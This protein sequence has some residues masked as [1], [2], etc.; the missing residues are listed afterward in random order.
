MQRINELSQG[1]S[2]AANIGLVL[3]NA[4]VGAAA[5]V[6]LAT[7]LSATSATQSSGLGAAAAFSRRAF[8]TSAA[9]APRWQQAQRHTRALHTAAVACGSGPPVVV[10][11]AV[12]D[13]VARASEALILETSN[14]GVVV[15]QY[16]GVGRNV[17]EAAGRLGAAPELVSVVGTG[18]AGDAL[19]THARSAGVVCSVAECVRCVCMHC[20]GKGS[21]LANIVCTSEACSRQHVCLALQQADLLPT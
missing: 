19:L 9:A 17:A 8:H 1:R 11:G 21:S 4:R 13:V 15:Q 3:N 20:R 6:D 16:G 10:G 14:P 12:I 7:R 18:T 2:L 5:A